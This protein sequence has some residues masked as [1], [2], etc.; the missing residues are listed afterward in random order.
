M[1]LTS[2]LLHALIDKIKNDFP[3]NYRTKLNFRSEKRTKAYRY[4][5]CYQNKPVDLAY[6]LIEYQSQPTPL[7][8]IHFLAYIVDDKYNLFPKIDDTDLKK[9]FLVQQQQSNVSL[10][11]RDYLRKNIAWAFSISFFSLF[12][13]KNQNPEISSLEKISSLEEYIFLNILIGNLNCE[14]LV[15]IHYQLPNH[16]RLENLSYPIDCGH[17]FKYIEDF[18][19]NGKFDNC[20][21]LIDVFDVKNIK[22]RDQFPQIPTWIPENVWINL[23]LNFNYIS[24]QEV[25][26]ITEKV[27]SCHHSKIR[28]SFLAILD[29]KHLLS[30][31]LIYDFDDIE[32]FS[33]VGSST[34]YPI[35]S[36]DVVLKPRSNLENRKKT[37]RLL[38]D[39]DFVKNDIIKWEEFLVNETDLVYLYAN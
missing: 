24:F 13:N 33:T 20:E 25:L 10:S 31:L 19:W 32:I 11:Q 8:L 6:C 27:V 17:H 38:L 21:H 16:I 29:F 4:W 22:L 2:L 30:H 7:S 26:N 14:D 23:S 3:F 15:K 1:K 39:D 12:F 36:V 34:M 37:F 18:F 28:I 35:Y 5:I 9:I